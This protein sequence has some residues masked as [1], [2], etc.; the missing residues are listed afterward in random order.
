MVVMKDDQFSLVKWPLARVLA[1]HVYRK[2][3][4]IRAVDLKT[5]TC[6]TTRPIVK[7]IKLPID[8]DTEKVMLELEKKNVEQQEPQ[9]EE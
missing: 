2:D 5:G 7:L 6:E 9:P 1:M 3:A 4:L 8:D